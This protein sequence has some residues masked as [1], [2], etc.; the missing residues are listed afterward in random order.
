MIPLSGWVLAAA[1]LITGPA[2]WASL[3]EH[4]MPIDVALTRFLLVTA[5]C[6]VAFSVA[7]ELLRPVPA[8]RAIAGEDGSDQ[9]S[10]EPDAGH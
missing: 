5:G 7:A 9:H 8:A 1:A 4:T 2:L 3:V 6:W 10:P